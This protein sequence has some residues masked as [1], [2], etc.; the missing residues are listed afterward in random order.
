MNSAL[1]TAEEL[2]AFATHAFGYATA[3]FDIAP[4]LVTLEYL[5][6]HGERFTDVRAVAYGRPRGCY[7]NASDFIWQKR[8][9][10]YVQGFVLDGGLVVGHAWCIETDGTPLEVTWP[11]PL[12]IYYGVHFSLGQLCALQ[13][14]TE[15]YDWYEDL[16][17]ITSSENVANQIKLA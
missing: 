4:P 9:R 5:R 14:S 8:G 10:R 6:E 15:S 16:S 11:E 13:L 12:G 17:P 3:N 7:K 2:E 1:A